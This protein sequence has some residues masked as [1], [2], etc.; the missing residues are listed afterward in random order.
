MEIHNIQNTTHTFKALRLKKGSASYIESMPKQVSDKLDTISKN[1]ENTSYYHLDIGKD[2]Y[3]ICH[4]DGE[5]Y[6]LPINII[7][8]GKVIIIKAKQG[9]TQI[10]VK[11]KYKTTN[12]VKNILE[13][14]KSAKTQIER[15]SAIV[16]VLDNYEKEYK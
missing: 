9:L 14:I 10:S 16:K 3:Y 15:T 13:Q 1:L 7:N 5:K 8:A 6:F 12:E 2:D 11:L 4:N